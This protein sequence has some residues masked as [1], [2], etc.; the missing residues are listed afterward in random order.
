MA[1]S[2]TPSM[3]VAPA[4]KFNPP[5]DESVIV[6]A[7]QRNDLVVGFILNRPIGLTVNNL[8]DHE[9]ELSS[10]CD[11]PILFGGPSKK[12]SGFIMY[13]HDKKTPLAKGFMIS[14]TV[15]ISP[16]L[17]LLKKAINGELDGRFELFLGCSTWRKEQLFAELSKGEWLHTPFCHELLFDIE[18]E[19]RWSFSFKNLGISPYSFVSVAGGAQA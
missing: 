14:S 15:S 1:N 2:I 6:L 10:N 19:Q 3:L 9:E 16:S 7:G 5:F 8:L 13:E 12:N 4:S 11:K 18:P 17:T